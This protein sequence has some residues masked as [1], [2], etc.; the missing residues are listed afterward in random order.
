MA[1]APHRRGPNG[2]LMVPFDRGTD[3]LWVY[4][5]VGPRLLALVFSSNT[6]VLRALT[7]MLPAIALRDQ[8][9]QGKII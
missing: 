7:G 1:V 6:R 8:D 5:A 2:K 3:A 9:E 4:V